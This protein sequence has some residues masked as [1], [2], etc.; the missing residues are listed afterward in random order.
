LANPHGGP[1]L[2]EVAPAHRFDIAALDAYLRDRVEAF[3]ENLVVRQFQGG[4]SN[5]TFLLTTEGPDGPRRYVMRKKPP[6][7]L[8]ASAHQVDREFRIM[9]ALAQTDVPVPTMRVLCEDDAVIG[10]AFYLMDYLEGRILTD[11]GLPSMSPADR[12]AAYDDFGATLA[13]LHQVDYEAIGLGDFNRPGDYIDRQ[14]SRFTKQY[15]SAETE[16]IAEMERL[17]ERLPTMVPPDRRVTIVHGDY[18][19]GNVMFHPTEPRLIGVLDWELCTVGDPLAD[20]A[21][22]AFPWRRT[23]TGGTTDMSLPGI[24]TEAEY[25]AAYCRRTGRDGI[26]GWNFY[27]AFGLFR[28]ASI[29]QGVYRRVL[30]G[31]VASEHPAVNQAPTLARSALEILMAG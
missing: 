2:V 22:S 20:L 18:K 31:V 9:K 19:M 24:P 5:P 28:L 3:G 6:G 30:S 17:I 8:L 10:T 23:G 4:V 27:L 7:V 13:R 29:T 14:L 25:K 26:E 12:A 16:T 1:A 21:F 15:R 11:A